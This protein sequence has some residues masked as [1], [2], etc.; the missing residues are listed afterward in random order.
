MDEG[1]DVPADGAELETATLQNHLKSFILK[2]E[3][4]QEE[5]EHKSLS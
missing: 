4:K 1:A 3:G 2:L 5:R